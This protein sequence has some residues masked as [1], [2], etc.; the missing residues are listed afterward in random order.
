[1]VV[2]PSELGRDFVVLQ[3]SSAL[4][5]FG[6][7]IF[8]LLFNLY[9]LERGFNERFLG[10]VA[11]AMTAGTLVGA[12]PAV[13]LTRRAGLRVALWLPFLAG[14]QQ[15]FFELSLCMKARS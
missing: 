1:M 5:D 8:F 15:A 14:R 13:T 4:F 11:A 6:E 3:L 7:S 9:L 2:D 12:I 10:Q